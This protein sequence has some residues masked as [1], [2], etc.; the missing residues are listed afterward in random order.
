MGS[1]EHAP[2]I[3]CVLVQWKSDVVI[4]LTE[5]SAV[6]HYL[7]MTSE[8]VTIDTETSFTFS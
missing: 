3:E 4:F 1:F 2:T 5:L 6:I 8:N 7:T